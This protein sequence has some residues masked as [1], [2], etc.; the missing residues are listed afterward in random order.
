[1]GTLLLLGVGN[2]IGGGGSSGTMEYMDSTAFGWMDNTN[3]D[4]L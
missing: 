2:V 4:W 3:G 1:M